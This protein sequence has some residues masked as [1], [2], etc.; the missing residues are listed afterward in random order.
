MS[1]VNT[2]LGPS[3]PE[4]LGVTLMQ[5]HILVG[6]PGWQF[7]ATA[8]PFDRREALARAVDRMQEIT[9]LG[10]ETIVD[11]CP[12]DFGR[13]VEFIAEVAQRSGM[14]IICS[15]GL[16]A[17]PPYFT[18]LD[19]EAIAA[20]YIK[21]ITEGVGQ[22]GIKPGILKVATQS[23]VTLTEEKNLRAIAKAAKATGVPI[24]THTDNA[25]E[26]DKQLDIFQ[27]EGISAG[28]VVIG[29]S[30]GRA[31]LSYHVTIMDRG[32]FVGF[33]RWGLEVYIPDK[34]RLACLIGL[35]GIGYDDHIVL[36][37]DSIGCWLGRP[38]LD[39]PLDSPLYANWYPTHLF[40]DIFPKLKEAGV[41]ET[42]VRKMLVDNPRR[43]FEAA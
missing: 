1:G 31:D 37:H 22:T 43:L 42:S 35:V 3:R 21:E 38:L 14:R 2:V 17:L 15:A 33:D 11:P 23:P 9:G 18:Q 16:F 5:E 40:K 28:R 13:D 4:E 20:V 41:S 27:E 32:A 8:P 25:S 7:D 12:T 39:P 29:H 34:L 6:L 26:G 19:S 10:V 30:D 36:A 24:L